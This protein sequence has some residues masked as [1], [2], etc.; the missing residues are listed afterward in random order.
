MRLVGKKKTP[1]YLPACKRT[2]LVV[3]IMRRPLVQSSVVGHVVICRALVCPE[4][5]RIRAGLKKWKRNYNLLQHNPT[6]FLPLSSPACCRFYI[7]ASP[8]CSHVASDTFS[9]DAPHRHRRIAST[10]TTR[11]TL[12]SLDS[13][14]LPRPV[15]E[16]DSVSLYAFSFRIDKH[17]PHRRVNYAAP[18]CPNWPASPHRW[19]HCSVS[20]RPQK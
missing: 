1:P 19:A 9:A 7:L 14:L 12:T 16:I 3:V 18:S 11:T 6:F 15:S 17:L 10:W 13:F 5:L 8:P 4:I 20:L 2:R